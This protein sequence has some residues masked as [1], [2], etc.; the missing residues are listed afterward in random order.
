MRGLAVN[1]GHLLYTTTLWNLGWLHQQVYQPALGGD[2]RY[3]WVSFDSLQ[4]PAFSR[5]EWDRAKEAM[6][7]WKFDMRYR[8]IYRKPAGL[9]YSD[10]D[11]SYATFQPIKLEGDEEKYAPGPGRYTGAGHLVKPFTIPT[12]WLRRVGVDFGAS[13]HNAQLWAARDPETDCWY[14]YREVSQVSAT[15]PEQARSAAEYQE[16]VD[17]GVGG[18]PS[19]DDAR[20]EWTVSGFSVIEP[21]ISEVEP[22]IDRA[23]GL[24]RQHRLFIFDTLTRTRSDLGTYSRELDDAGEP[25]QRIKDKEKF[26]LVDGLRYLCTTIGLAPTPD[27]TEAEPP[28]EGRSVEFIEW[29]AEQGQPRVSEEYT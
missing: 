13:L 25:L 5:K 6:P 2:K 15:G 11:D 16:P 20:M 29:Q 28:K 8:G 19:E 14:A 3:R 22:G 23:I 10:Y 27:A 26:H 18:A 17:Y 21:P 1:E 12:H 24:F 9:I 4:N 7:E